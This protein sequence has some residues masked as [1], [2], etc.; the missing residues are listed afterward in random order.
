MIDPFIQSLLFL[1]VAPE[2]AT[3]H[4]TKLSMTFSFDAKRVINKPFHNIVVSDDTSNGAATSTSSPPRVHSQSPIAVTPLREVN[5]LRTNFLE[6]YKR[7]RIELQVFHF[8][9]YLFLSDE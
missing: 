8:T 1:N 6:K 2:A 7:R 9:F 3:L 5:N 4:D